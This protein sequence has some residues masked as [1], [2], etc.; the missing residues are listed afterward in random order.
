MVTPLVLSWSGGK[1]ANLSLDA[2]R[3]GDEYEVVG[4]LTTLSREYRRISMHGVRETLL[5][6]QAAAVD[7]PLYKVWLPETP[8]NAA[9]EAV[10]KSML[11]TI[12]ADGVNHV[13]FGDILLED[14]R[15]YREK[16]MAQIG[17]QTVFP[18]WRQSTSTLAQRFIGDGYR[19]IL[20]CVDTRQLDAGFAGHEY[21][22]QL[23][24]DLPPGCDPCGESGEFHSFVYDA[25]RFQRPISVTTGE[26][27]LRDNRFQ[28]RDLLPA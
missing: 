1:D 4:L 20:T 9:Y 6:A 16:Q 27:V 13:A 18:L 19:A 11:E 26:S 14:V 17:M 8:D 15:A 3:R 7:L 21:D 10:M 2:L 5:D 22:Q 25:P 23:L 12:R 24:N 28:F